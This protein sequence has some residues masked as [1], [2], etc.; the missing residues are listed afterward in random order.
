[1]HD[2]PTTFLGSGGAHKHN[3]LHSFKFSFYIMIICYVSKI[4]YVT[5]HCYTAY[6]TFIS[7]KLY[8]PGYV[9][10]VITDWIMSSITY[11]YK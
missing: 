1:M 3:L 10:H 8:I 2:I 4:C 9:T 11:R 7:E 6:V 5:C